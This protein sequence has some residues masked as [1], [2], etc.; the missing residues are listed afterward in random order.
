[1]SS[2]S[3]DE[4]RRR[5]AIV[6]SQMREDVG[7]LVR[8]ARIKTDWRHYVERYPWL[9]L[10]AA[11]LVGFWLVPTAAKKFVLDPAL[12]SRLTSGQVPVATNRG[13]S[14]LGTVSGTVVPLLTRIAVTKLLAHFLDAEP[15]ADQPAAAPVTDVFSRPPTKPK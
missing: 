13:K 7:A 2:D 5:M 11:T 10:G 8:S 6:R 15:P 12:L 3:A 1:M 14:V 4:I 9:S